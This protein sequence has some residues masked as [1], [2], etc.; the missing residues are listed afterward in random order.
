MSTFCDDCKKK[1]TFLASITFSWKKCQKC[2]KILCS[3][4]KN[5]YEYPY[6]FNYYRR[7][8]IDHLPKTLQNNDYS[9]ILCKQCYRSFEQN[10]KKM[11]DKIMVAI[12][13]NSEVET[14]SANYKGKVKVSGKKY[15]ILTNFHKDRDDAKEELKTIAR[16]L[17]CDIVIDESLHKS[18]RE[19]ETDSGNTY[20]YSVWCFSGI[21]THKS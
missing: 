18:T 19:E 20:T 12:N 16:I 15:P 4:C 2:S 21:A 1:K 17:E 10:E 5:K 3:K 14:V 13:S 7:L 6:Y 11:I 9:R 8:C